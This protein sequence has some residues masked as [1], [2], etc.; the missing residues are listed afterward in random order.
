M[1]PFADRPGGLKV[2]VGQVGGGGSQVVVRTAGCG[3]G[4]NRFTAWQVLVVLFSNSKVERRYFGFSRS[5]TGKSDR[6]RCAM[7]TNGRW[8]RMVLVRGKRDHGKAK[9]AC[10]SAQLV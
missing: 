7:T 3:S 2:R 9:K 1:R 6:W 5:S 10:L 4:P 8:N